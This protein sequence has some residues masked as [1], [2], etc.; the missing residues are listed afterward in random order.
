M[1]KKLIVLLAIAAVAYAAWAYLSGRE[2]GGS[3]E[4]TP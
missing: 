4:S 2:A 3:S 1:I